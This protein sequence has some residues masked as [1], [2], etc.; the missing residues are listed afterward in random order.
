MVPD[1]RS[2]PATRPRDPGGAVT[3]IAANGLGSSG[4]IAAADGYLWF[5]D[6]GG[7][8]LGHV[9]FGGAVTDWPVTPIRA[10][11]DIAAG[12]DGN[13]WV[14]S[15]NPGRIGRITDDFEVTAFTPFGMPT[16]DSIAAGSDGN[17]WFT[18]RD[19][20]AVGRI[21]PAGV[22]TTYSLG[23]FSN[24]TAIARGSDGNMWF[25]DD[26]RGSIGRVS[27]AGQFADFPAS[28]VPST[29]P[30][31]LAAAPDGSLWF[32]SYVDDRVGRITT[33]GTITWISSPEID[34]PRHIAVAPD[35]S[36]WVA[37]APPLNPSNPVFPS[38]VRIAVD[39]TVATILGP[40]LFL[41]IP[42]LEIGPDG[43]IWFLSTGGYARLTPDGTNLAPMPGGSAP[44]GAP[45][46]VG[47]EGAMWWG[48]GASAGR[49]KAIPDGVPTFPGAVAGKER[50]TV[51]WQAPRTPVEEP[52]TGYTGPRRRRAPSLHD[53]G[54]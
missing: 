46:V 5:T 50:A 15:T 51:S 48:I 40:S 22:P 29:T 21:T 37:T 12:P 18:D 26:G 13:L 19:H 11:N 49:L 16:P 42:D 3:L 20:G 31:D 47:P 14:T 6:R 38:L 27:P 35:G 41:N 8:E 23:G 2:Q 45:M 39:G 7:D 34:G 33:D 17:L 10:M 4:S 44:V 1:Q 30:N 53:D 24:P 9:T 28:R 36:V 43:A 54:G 25:V 52:I 32:T